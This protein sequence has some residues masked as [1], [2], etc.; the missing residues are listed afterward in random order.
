M[1][2]G[3]LGT[4][5]NYSQQME[6]LRNQ[7]GT[8]VAKDPPVLSSIRSLDSALTQLQAEMEV[9]NTRLVSVL[10]SQAATESA[11]EPNIILSGG[12]SLCCTLHD[13][14]LRVQHQI[15]VVQALVARLEI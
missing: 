13:L 7:A 6:A 1:N 12:G 8:P 5:T 11:M 9:L 15:F 10:S 3:L 14:A 4:S 2:P